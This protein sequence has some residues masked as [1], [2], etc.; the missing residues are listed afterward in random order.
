MNP[1]NTQS[2]RRSAPAWLQG[3]QGPQGPGVGDTGPQGHQGFQGF[4]G[5]QGLRG[6]QGMRGEQGFQ[7]YQGFQGNGIQG[8][9]GPQGLIGRHGYVG[10]KGDQGF[11]GF[12]GESGF[13]GYQGNQGFQGSQ[14]P[15][16]EQ[17]EKGDQ[18]ETGVQ[19][20]QG[21]V[22]VGLTGPKGVQGP[23]GI[24]GYG[25]KD[26]YQGVQGPPGTL[27]GSV[28][29]QLWSSQ[30]DLV[31]REFVQGSSGLSHS[32][33][34]HGITGRKGQLLEFEASGYVMIASNGDGILRHR[35]DVSIGSTQLFQHYLDDI[36]LTQALQTVPFHIRGLVM[37]TATNKQL[38][39]LFVN[40]DGTFGPAQS[41]SEELLNTENFH[42]G[43]TLVNSDFA[44]HVQGQLT[45]EYAY[46]RR[47]S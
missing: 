9:V 3:N 20:Y 23:V 37:S 34:L 10:P 35:F 2:F 30:F 13:Q 21:F 28:A 44:E 5:I 31:Q 39:K 46:V 4:Q 16:G 6:E 19:G 25:G 11:Q 22:G 33:I 29:N 15:I 12:V 14:G 36:D 42:L 17:G 45:I 18:G 38:T 1:L 27:Y 47:L 32:V 8:D 43:Y 7:G 41:S 26:G 24:Q 40:H